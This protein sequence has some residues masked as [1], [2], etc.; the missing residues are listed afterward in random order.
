MA[1]IA[2]LRTLLRDSA[3]SLVAWILVGIHAAWFFLAVAN[4]GLPKPAFGFPDTGQWAFRTS[5]ESLLAGRPFH[6]HYEPLSVKVLFVADLP[7]LIAAV[8][9]A[10]VVNVLLIPL[11]VSRYVGSYF[12]AVIWLL[13]S[14]CQWLLIGHLLQARRNSRPA[15]SSKS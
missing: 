12:G 5:N 10:M 9:V 8:P 1:I 6:F 15:A 13:A 7:A 4:M 2:G 3:R 14:S 11:R